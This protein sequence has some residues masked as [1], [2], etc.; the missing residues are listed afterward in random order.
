MT[1]TAGGHINLSENSYEVR[2]IMPYRRPSVYHAIILTFQ[3]ESVN[4]QMHQIFKLFF[5][6]CVHFSLKN[7]HFSKKREKC[8]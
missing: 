6:S 1:V 8:R 2:D 7:A 3:A 4:V 5:V